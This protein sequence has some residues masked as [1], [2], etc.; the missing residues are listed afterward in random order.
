MKSVAPGTKRIQIDAL[1]E[2]CNTYRYKGVIREGKQVL[3]ECGHFHVNR[4]N[5]S[6]AYIRYGHVEGMS[7]GT[8]ALKQARLFEAN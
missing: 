6:Y 2:N 7:A 8:C 5:D 4:D 1:Y 3:W